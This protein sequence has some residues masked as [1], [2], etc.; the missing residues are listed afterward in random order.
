MSIAGVIAPYRQ[1]GVSTAMNEPI[2]E[3]RVAEGDRVEEGQVLAVLLT[4]DLQAQLASAQ[5]T[6]V[7]GADRS[8]QAS[9]QALLNGGGYRTALV[10]AR[11]AFRQ[12]QS[13][14]AGALTDRAR[15]AGLFRSGYVS[16]QVLAQQDVTVQQDR[17][18]VG[19]AG[20]LLRQAEDASRIGT[21]PGGLESVQI[22]AARAAAGSASLAVE[23][24]RRQISRATIVAP[25][26]GIVEAVNAGVGEYPSGRQLFTIH[27]DG[28][29]FA[30]L[31]AGSLEAARI[32]AGQDVSVLLAGG[33]VR[34]AGRVVAL[35][36]QLAPG[37]TNYT[38][39]VLVG[40]TAQGVLPGMPV[41]GVVHLHPVAGV[42]V[43][44]SA[45]TDP[46]HGSVFVVSGGKA[47]QHAVNVLAEDGTNAAVRGLPAGARVVKDGQGGVGDGDEV[48]AK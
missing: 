30:M 29:V 15:Y 35:L 23:A 44:V 9:S 31:A 36:D 39:K 7:E 19:A 17:Q 3:I 34:A 42:V 26:S 41:T 45:Y 25:S 10:D 21:A 40:R 5:A 12:S 37:S 28:S 1:I 47:R 24:L 22:D 46:M 6:A 33:T 20:S 13:A 8:T 38:V 11:A 27:D 4:D 32:R 43:P 18:A 2:A 48:R 14:L 16:Q